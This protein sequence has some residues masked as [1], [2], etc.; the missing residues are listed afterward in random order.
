MRC[1]A[2]CGSCFPPVRWVAPLLQ[3]RTPSRVHLPTPQTRAQPTL[4]PIRMAAFKIGSFN[5]IPAFIV[6]TLSCVEQRCGGLQAAA[7]R[8]RRRRL[9]SEARRKGGYLYFPTTF[10]RPFFAQDCGHWR[11]TVRRQV[12]AQRRGALR[13]RRWP[14]PFSRQRLCSA[15]QPAPSLSSSQP[16]AA[17]GA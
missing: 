3:T 7:R 2:A 17:P 13:Q 14:S 10:R 16:A 12:A 1:G 8:R 5:L 15:T 6:T 11:T 9:R 4:T